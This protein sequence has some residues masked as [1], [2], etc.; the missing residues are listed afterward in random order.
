MNS[1]HWPAPC[2]GDALRAG[3]RWRATAGSTQNRPRPPASV[4]S[5][6]KARR[7]EAVNRN[8]AIV[9]PVRSKNAPALG[10]TAVMVSSQADLDAICR[11][12][13]REGKPYRPLFNSRLYPGEDLSLVGP[14]IGAPYAVMLLETLVAWGV[15]SVLFLGWCGA[16]SPQVVTGDIL[17]PTGAIVD[18]GTSPHYGLGAGQQAVP[19]AGLLEAV[20][21][22]FE[23][24]ALPLKEG[25]VWSTDAIYR[26]TRD[27]VAYYQSI[28]AVA[29]EMEL[30]ALFAVGHFR[31]VDIA[32]LLVVSDELSCF[33]WRPGFKDSRFKAARSRAVA[34]IE[35]ICRNL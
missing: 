19:S 1:P 15:D 31:K 21:R 33:E 2:D 13:E 14:L 27:K 16:I 5:D 22:G 32:G 12:L 34:G 18:E 3:V 29:V 26:E 28:G 9:N 11:R 23:D 6:S 7:E 35:R 10:P 20:R 17:L 25:L 24:C 30:S 8:E 4:F